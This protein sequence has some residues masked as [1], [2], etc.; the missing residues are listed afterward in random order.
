MTYM[1][2]SD[3]SKLVEVAMR[4]ERFMANDKKNK[5]SKKDPYGQSLNSLRGD[6]RHGET[7]RQMLDIQQQENFKTHSHNPSGFRTSYGGFQRHNRCQEKGE[8][9]YTCGQQGHFAK[10][11][12]NVGNASDCKVSIE[13]VTMKVDLILFVLDELDVIS[14]MHFLTKYHVVL[15]CSNKES[16]LQE[17]GR[18]LMHKYVDESGKDVGNQILDAERDVRT[19]I[20]RNT[21]RDRFPTCHQQ[22]VEN[23]FLPTSSLPMSS[24]HRQQVI[25]DVHT[26]LGIMWWSL[27]CPSHVFYE[28]PHSFHF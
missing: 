23:T 11:C 20:E 27:L 16:T 18:L 15:D 8:N 19:T 22:G 5:I 13:N 26:K 4:D 14:G 6:E 28:L 12:P 3:F 24:M 2:W 10:Y 17:V 25:L 9:Y 1:D 21:S 7:M